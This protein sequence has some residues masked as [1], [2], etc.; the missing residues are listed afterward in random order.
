MRALEDMVVGLVRSETY[1]AFVRQKGIVAVGE[2]AGGTDGMQMFHDGRP[3][4]AVLF[5]NL[6]M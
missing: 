2:V 1:W 6:F 4:F 5:N 3:S